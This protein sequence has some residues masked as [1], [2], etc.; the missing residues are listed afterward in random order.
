MR[1]HLLLCCDEWTTTV[2]R[3]SNSWRRLRS[4]RPAPKFAIDVVCGVYRG[5]RFVA[6]RLAGLTRTNRFVQIG[7]RV[8]VD[9]LR[10]AANFERVVQFVR[11]HRNA[12]DFREVCADGNPEISPLA[13]GG[14][15]G[16]P[17]AETRRQ[18]LAE[19]DVND[20]VRSIETIDDARECRRAG[21][22]VADGF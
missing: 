11:D 19:P 20:D 7:Q 15:E 21:D 1:S 6:L 3:V 12:L 10:T 18:Q 4:G 9:N 22:A 14:D 17:A 16:R 2:R 13:S 8:E 5:S